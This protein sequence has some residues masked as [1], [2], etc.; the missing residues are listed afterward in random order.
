MHDLWMD[1][2]KVKDWMQQLA[3]K[4]YKNLR[5]R[6]NEVIYIYQSVVVYNVSGYVNMGFVSQYHFVLFSVKSLFTSQVQNT[7]TCNTKY[8]ALQ[9]VCLL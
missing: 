6:K 5:R 9:N 8:N 1:E 7:D 2:L 4:K 3:A